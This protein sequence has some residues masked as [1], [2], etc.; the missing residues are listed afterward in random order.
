MWFASVEAAT[1]FSRRECLA[2]AVVICCGVCQISFGA[3]RSIGRTVAGAKGALW[4]AE[5][6]QEMLAAVPPD[7]SVTAGIPFLSHL[8]LRENLHSLHHVLKGLKTLSRSLYVP[9]EATDAVVFDAA[10]P[11]T[12]SRVAGYYHQTMQLPDGSFLPS[13]DA[14]LHQFL[15]AHSW[16]IITRNSFTIYLR[17]PAAPLDPSQGAPT[18]IDEHTRLV[19]V[20]PMPPAPGDQMLLGLAWEFTAGRV[21]FPWVTLYLRDAA[22]PGSPLLPIQKGPVPLGA[23]EGRL[24]EYWSVRRTPGI[25]AGRYHALLLIYDPHAGL[26]S[27]GPP[28]LI[29]QRW[30]DLGEFS[31]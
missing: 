21:H 29:G 12:F 2:L 3:V 31:L 14:L 17:K 9:P 4:S 18:E 27:A 11:E 22:A 7:A 28:C 25:P 13:S 6:K 1:R 30:I 8:A 24:R 5:W 15:K 10:D 26:I 23:D 20:V 16:Q 19:N